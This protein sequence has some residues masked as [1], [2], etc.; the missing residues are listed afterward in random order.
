MPEETKKPAGSWRIVLIIVIVL[1]VLFGAYL[2]LAWV[3][4]KANN[5]IENGIQPTATAGQGSKATDQS[6]VGTW[7]SECLVP[8]PDSPWSEKHQFTF[9][10]DGTA[11]HIRWSS[12]G[13]DCSPETTLTDN[14]QYSLPAAGQID[15]KDTEKG[16]TIYDIYKISGN[17][18]VFGHGF[19]N[20]LP[21]PAS[22]GESAAGRIDSLN[23]YIVYKK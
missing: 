6:L 9:N 17:T 16:A 4:R 2:G 18:L 13:H 22:N 11:T 12:D 20:T 15:L 19:R 1:V 7:V 14:Y 10:K 23:E 21:Y 5:A 3:L 8:D